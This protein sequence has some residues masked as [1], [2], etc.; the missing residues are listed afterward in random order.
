[1]ANVQQN[2]SLSINILILEGCTRLTVY[3]QFCIY[4]FKHIHFSLSLSLSFQ[5][6]Y[7]YTP[8]VYPTVLRSIGVGSCSGMARLGAALTPYVAQVLMKTSLHLAIGVY[9]SVALI[10]AFSCLLLPFE[11][12]G[13]EMSDGSNH[14]T[15]LTSA[16]T[17]KFSN[18]ANT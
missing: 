4:T 2:I 6:A 1:M 9:V 10:A 5:A 7:V 8:E 11:T 18:S 17:N 13:H 14:T 12:R 3:T 16:Q 15:S